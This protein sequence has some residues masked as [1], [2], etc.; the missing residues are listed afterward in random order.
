[1]LQTS[2]KRTR[3]LTI[4][5]LA[6]FSDFYADV[7]DNNTVGL[8]VGYILGCVRRQTHNWTLAL[9]WRITPW[10]REVI[11]RTYFS[12][13]NTHDWEV[14]C[15]QCKEMLASHK[16]SRVD[17]SGRVVSPNCCTPLKPRYASSTH[18]PCCCNRP[19]VHVYNA[20]VRRRLYWRLRLRNKRMS[21][22]EG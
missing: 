16:R 2:C 9:G 5:P 13:M 18:S 15:F 22:Q 12:I 17:A 8:F 4:I 1:M 3:D 10:R 14:L 6:H 11:L 20:R 21:V 7:D 19:V